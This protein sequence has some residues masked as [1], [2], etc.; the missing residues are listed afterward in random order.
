MNDT[1][2]D[3][4]VHRLGLVYVPDIVETDAGPIDEGKLQAFLE[5][6][7]IPNASATAREILKTHPGLDFDRRPDGSFEV[8]TSY[9]GV[10]VGGFEQSVFRP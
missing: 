10:Y 4:D 2:K 6:V 1:P 7:L 8:T 5:Q 9:A 3:P